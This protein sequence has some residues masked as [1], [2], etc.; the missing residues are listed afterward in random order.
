MRLKLATLS[1]FLFMHTALATPTHPISVLTLNLAN[2]NDHIYWDQR[3]Q[4]IVDTIEK[5]HADIVAL[6]ETR[7]D[8]DHP[9]SAN[10][11]QDM[12]QQILYQLHLR[13]DYLQAQ[14]VTQPIM[15]YP[16]TTN[17]ALGTHYYPLP[18]SLA[19]DKQDY[20]WEGVSIISKFP[21]L[22]T[23]SVFLSQPANCTDDNK[24]AT[25]YIKIDNQGDQ[26]YIANVHMSGNAC[27]AKQMQETVGYLEKRLK[28]KNVF[29]VGDF[30]ATPTDTAFQQFTKL[31]LVDLWAKLHPNEDGS[32]SSAENP[33]RR[34]D[35]IWVSKN[36]ADSF[37]D[38]GQ[39]QIIANQR[40]GG[41]YP[42]D[43]FGLVARMLQ[44]K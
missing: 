18:S 31:G 35:Y 41:Q 16:H 34:I 8:P 36:V 4:L 2:Y 43:H 7:Y 30:N 15:Y 44:S 27:F 29:V 10:S 26:F 5:A 23:G 11:H 1:T 9:S 25:Q 24:R 37:S 21:I 40:Q 12:A 33:L 20:Y 19:P 13:G 14:L 39:I 28:Y 32:T 6:Q 38:P 17:G 3:L 42:S 22:E